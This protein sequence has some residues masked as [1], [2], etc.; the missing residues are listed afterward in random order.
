MSALDEMISGL[1]GLGKLEE[2][3]A[4]IAAPMLE[5][6]LKAT[7]A[8][9]TTPSGEPWA[10]TKKGAR[11]MKGAAKAV[12]AKAFGDVVRVSLTGPEVFHHAGVRGEPRRQ[13]IPYGGVDM[14]PEVKTIID[15]ATAQAFDEITGGAR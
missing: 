3:A 6:E 8:A 12:A 2:R 4:A 7:A 1:R 11:A 14:L 10:P 5:A 13:V 9:G 15:K